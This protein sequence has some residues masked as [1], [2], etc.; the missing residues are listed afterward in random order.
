[1]GAIE[2]C[3]IGTLV[4]ALVESVSAKEPVSW[5]GALLRVVIATVTPLLIAIT[6]LVNNQ[7]KPLVL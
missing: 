1:M 2:R 3:S 7:I 4:H 5:I 6:V